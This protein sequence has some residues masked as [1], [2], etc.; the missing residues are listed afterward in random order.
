MQELLDTV[1][2]K[3]EIIGQISRQELSRDPRAIV[4]MVGVLVT[5]PED[6]KALLQL[7]HRRKELYPSHWTLSATGHVQS[8]E[9]YH[10]AAKRELEEEV[11]IL[12]DN[13]IFMRKELLSYDGVQRWWEFFRCVSEA[14]PVI[15]ASE[16]ERVEYVDLETN[17]DSMLLPTM[18]N[19]S[20]SLRFY[21]QVI[22][23]DHKE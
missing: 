4:R 23:T 15:Q 11:G 18:K 10:D 6:G 19:I 12:S 5:R 9:G 20:P 21:L 14:V 3:D 22:M 16:V 2:E 17:G 7:R 13:L 1:N 8:G